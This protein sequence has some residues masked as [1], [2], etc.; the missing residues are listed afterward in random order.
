MSL[1]QKPENSSNP[2][3]L[4]MKLLVIDDEPFNVALLEK[5]LKRAG[6]HNIYTSTDPRDT[7]ELCDQHD[8]DLILLDLRMPHLNGFEVMEK[9][10]ESENHH[11]LPVL[12]LT[13]ENSKENRLQALQNG[14]KD[15]VSKPFDRSEV[16]TRIHNILENKQLYNHLKQQNRNLDRIV[17]ERTRELRQEQRHLEELNNS[18]EDMV[19]TRT[20]DLRLANEELERVNNTMSELVSIVSHE[21]RTPL[22]SIKS[23][24]EI[25]RDEADNLEQEDRNKFLT[26]I[27]KE[28]D[29]LTR[30]ISDLL[31]LQKMHSGKMVWKSE[32]LDIAQVLQNSVE[33]FTPAYN[34]KNLSLE[35][36]TDLNVANTLADA[37]KFQQVLSNLFSNAL[38]F[39]DQGGVEVKLCVQNNWAHSLLLTKDDHTAEVLNDICANNDVKLTHC[40][41]IKDALDYIESSGGMVDMMI[42]DLSSSDSSSVDDLGEIRNRFPSL[43]IATV[44]NTGAENEYSKSCMATIKKPIDPQDTNSVIE[45]VLNNLIGLN[46]K[47]K[48]INISIKDSGSGIPKEDLIK[49]F[50]QFHQVDSSQIRE[51]RGTG[52]GLAIS[53]EIIEHYGGK[54]WVESSVGI[55]STFHVL[56]PEF[57]EDKKKLGEILIE[58][59]IV[60]E[61][62][63]TEA[64][65]DQT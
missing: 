46:P 18:L 5:M 44:I 64:L 23:F 26:I 12:V 13:A 35:L 50:A 4:N 24:A 21:L 39:T 22:T 11:N 61:E 25:L 51:Q 33:F 54:I 55:G 41:Y 29:R 20:G 8:P 62:Q 63:L 37:D 17:Q 47:T 65:K 9:L 36:N 32:L 30:L 56:L 28:S 6:Y 53:Q 59:G 14:A 2:E 10:N 19:N 31:D 48:M 60:T 58:K 3:L 1:V 42:I 38:K 27:D 45:F 34:N 52:L 16:L 15:F 49:V 7:F 40:Q 57:R 43:P